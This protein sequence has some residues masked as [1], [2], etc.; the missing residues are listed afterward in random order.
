MVVL[1]WALGAREGLW[2]A[3]VAM[4]PLREAISIDFM[5]TAS[6]F[7][8]DLLILALLPW[9]IQEARLRRL[10]RESNVFRL[11]LVLLAL[12]LPGLYTATR[13]FWGV[14]S[15]YR[16]LVQ[17]A[18]FMTA[19][20]IV[21]SGQAAKRTLLAVLLGLLPTVAFGLYQTT[22]PAGSPLPD[23]AV[24]NLTYELGGEEHLRIVSTFDNAL[25]FSH[26][27]SAAIGIALGLCLSRPRGAQTAALLALTA[28]LVY[29]NLFTYTVGGILGMGS[30][31][32]IFLTRKPARRV[33]LVVVPLL[34]VVWFLVAPPAL[35]LKAETVFEGRA[36][37][38]AARIV[39]YKQALDILRDHPWLGVGWGGIWTRFEQDYRLT[40]ASQVGFGAENYFLQRAVALGLPGLA[41]YIA[42][43]VLFFRNV[44]RMPNED[45]PDPWPR[46]AL[47][48]CGVAFYVQAQTFPAADESANY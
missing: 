33:A 8:T 43:C 40:R 17:T 27:L 25:N 10:W 2:L 18:F 34:I 20:S 42:L 6:I 13:L 1:V 46:A 23:W 41:I 16:I 7:F 44:K 14:T 24:K 3:A 48:A 12:S 4:I 26:Y 35:V 21:R 30:A 32:A 15:V 9:T 39:T 38:S 37:A 22:L 45:S 47:L 28:S 19:F 31:L 29:A 5:G 11:G 36:A